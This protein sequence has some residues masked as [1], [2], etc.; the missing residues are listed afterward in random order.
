MAT[1]FTP[2]KLVD[3]KGVLHVARTAQEETHMRSNLGYRSAPAE[4]KTA[5]KP[6]QG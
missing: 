1:E 4:K 3:S 5:P 6:A 2:V